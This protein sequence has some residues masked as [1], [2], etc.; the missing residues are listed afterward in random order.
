L[1]I[2]HLNFHGKPP[3]T[4]KSSNDQCSMINDQ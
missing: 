3:P 2:G 4:Q 1:N